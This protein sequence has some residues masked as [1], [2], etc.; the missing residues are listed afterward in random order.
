MVEMEMSYET[1][2]NHISEIELLAG[3]GLLVDRLTG[4]VV[5][6]VEKGKVGELLSVYHVDT[7]IKHDGSATNFYDNA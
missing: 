3:L 5:S 7:A 1:G 2:V 6:A 4:R